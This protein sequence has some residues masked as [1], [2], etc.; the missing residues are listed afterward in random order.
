MDTRAEKI[1]AFILEK[2]A[3]YPGDI[4]DRTEK[5]FK[6]TRTTIHRHIKQ[7]IVNGNIIKTGKT[8]GVKYFLAGALDKELTFKISD[9]PEEHIVW[10]KYL[11]NSFS[12]LKENVEVVCNY[13]FGEMF[14]N[15]VDHSGGTTIIVKSHISG[16]NIKIMVWDDGIGVFK[17]IQDFLELNDIRESVLH[18]TKGK[19]T[20][21]P[22]IHT[23]EGI[24]FSSRAF[25]KYSIY[26]NGLL[27]LRDNFQDDWFLEDRENTIK[28]GTLIEM[29]I[30]KDSDTN[31]ENL[32]ASFQNSETLAF[33]K[34]HI[35][36]KFSKLGYERFIS[37]SQAK[38]I[39]I[40]LNKFNHII[41]DFK[42]INTVGQAFVDEVFRVFKSN[43]PG[44]KI[45]YIN[46]N[47]TI[48]FMIKRGITTSQVN[49][50]R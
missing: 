9:S 45:E 13:G 41:L 25:D 42:G 15:A 21:A 5:E 24:F 36:V 38:R 40:G 44:I 1:R 50:S 8:K 16:E 47:S 23:G 48:D 12:N 3:E 33:D 49:E 37:R 28:D 32:F 2:I 14:N 4:V 11:S 19:I 6:V 26:A 43:H 7:L 35:L 30:N 18:L 17:K 29:E 20:T 31:M 22:K 27:Y 34:T 39:L 46:A 10:D